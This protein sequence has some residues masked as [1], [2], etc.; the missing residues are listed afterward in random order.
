MS[1]V[2]STFFYL[3]QLLIAVALLA[4]GSLVTGFVRRTVLIAAVNA[5]LPSA[6]P[7]AGGVQAA[8]YA[9]VLAMALEHL[10]VGRQII[11]ISFAILFGG[12]VLALALSFGLAGRE[13]ARE[14]LENTLRRRPP[15]ERRENTLRHL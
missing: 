5:G 9:V 10:G 6:R 8:I 11:M 13:L 4:I 15:D 2:S 7:L 3:P 14:L 1:L 12:L